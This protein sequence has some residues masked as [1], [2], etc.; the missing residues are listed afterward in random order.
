MWGRT[1][2]LSVVFVLS[3]G[4]AGAAASTAASAA[5]SAFPDSFIGTID[6]PKA[7]APPPINGTLSDPAWKNAAVAHLTYN[8]REHRAANEQTTVYLMADSSYLYVGIDAK[9]S[10]PV[11][12]TEHT[13]MV[14]LDT[15]DEFQIDLW[16]NGTS[17][18][19]YKFTSTPIGTHYEY[20]TEN[21][22]FEPNWQSAGRTV[23]G[24][25]VINMRI[26]L[27]VMHGTGSGGW[28]V[29][30]IRYVVATNTP[31]V[32]SY[33]SAQQDFNSVNYSGALNGL[34]RLAAL[35]AKPRAGVYVLGSL[36]A[37]SI[38]GSTSRAGVDFSLPVLAGTSFVGTIH[39]DFSNVEVD[40]QTISPTAFQRIFNEVRPFF[41]QGANFYD[42]PNAT[43]INCPGTELYTP[44]IPTPRD[45][46]AIE[47]QRGLFNY[48]AFDAV[49]VGRVD[50]AQAFNYTSPNQQNFINL[51]R[52]SADYPGVH[53]DVTGVVLQHDNL[54]NF[55]QYLRYADNNGTDVLDRAQAQ[56][57]EAMMGYYTPTSSV[58]AVLRKIGAYFTPVDGLIQH[59]DIAGYDV[60]FSKQFKY[61]PQ[62]R[63]TELDVSGNLDRYHGHTEGLD[64]SDTG[65]NLSLNTRTLFNLQLST[66]SSY[67]VLAPNNFSPI[68]QQGVQLGYN[69]NS[70]T[71]TWVLFNTGRF[72]PGRLDSWQRNTTM[73][74]LKRFLVTL[75]ADDTDQYA[76][77]GQRYTQ[78]LE[79]LSFGYQASAN[80]SLA[81]GVRRI[82]GTP[83]QLTSVPT[84][85]DG[86]NL[87]AAFYRKVPGGEIYLVY[88]DASAFSTAPQFIVKWIRY[89]GAD[90]GT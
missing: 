85:V 81:I 10:T 82:I 54:K 67:V 71:P 76:D 40:Q 15:D 88:G 89:V 49:G 32:W 56:R 50:T 63:F 79:R 45:G 43:C 87:S 1:L 38:G 84:F 80:Q 39:P 27:G 55:V 19:R 42:Y 72:G 75:E 41:T 17:G 20:S 21:N 68:T 59:P 11:R 14:G 6:I 12:A 53:G 52:S 2:A 65:L 70:N 47:G 31:M 30:F 3:A 35:K 48:A 28:R 83:P 74:F 13:D 24:G 33:G 90:K 44:S 16:P 29:Q 78:W 8:L 64:Q 69:L 23:P 26:P 66:G 73:R 5:A 62:A 37:P 4:A 18:F 9:Q 86:W 51:Q 57:Y 60:Q 77:S 25:Y 34:P 22:S 7:D 36:A 58:Y 46:Y 61:S